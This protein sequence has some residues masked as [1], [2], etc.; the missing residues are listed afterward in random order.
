MSEA[1]ITEFLMMSTEQVDAAFE[2]WLTISFGVLIAVHITRSTT[3]KHLKIAMSVLYVTASMIIVLH[4][5]GDFMQIAEYKRQIDKSFAG[6]IPNSIAGVLR[7]LLYIL[8]TVGVAIAIFRYEHWIE[9][10]DT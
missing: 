7:L 10:D 6:E 2:F 8:G 9:N 1:E 4:T 3:S 5:L